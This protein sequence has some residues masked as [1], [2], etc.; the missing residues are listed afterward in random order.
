MTIRNLEEV[1]N[2]ASVALVCEGEAGDVQGAIALRNIL[3]GGYEGPFWLVHPECGTF[4]GHKCF[5]RLEDLPAAP[6][7]AVL[8]TPPRTVPERIAELGRKG[9]RIAVV[10]TPGIKDID[11]LSQ[12]VL[13]AAQPHML[14]VIGPDSLGVIAPGARL[15]ASVAH[16]MPQPGK[17]ALVSQS[18]AI[19][20][21]LIEWA[22]DH[23]I[24]F[25]HIVTMGDMADVDVS[26]YLDLLASDFN[27]RA[28]LIY[29]AHVQSARKFLSAARA[30]ARMKPVIAIK[31]GRTPQAARAAATHTGAMAAEDA[32]MDAALRRA[33]V[34]RVKGLSEM[35]A[36]AET[37]ARFRPL[38]R[39]RLGIV[40][41]GGGAG[42]LAVDR[43]MEGSGQLAELSPAT[44]EAFDAVLPPAWSGSNPVDILGD[45]DPARYVAALE[46]LA[47][48]RNVDVVMVI[49]C[50]SALGPSAAIAEAVAA[51][52]RRGMIG[53]KPVLACWLGGSEAREARRLMRRAEMAT[54]STPSS[55]AAAV[56]HL[57]DW[58]RAQAALL[59]VPDRAVEGSLRSTPIDAAETARAIF[60]RVAEGGR[61]MLTE[62]EAKAAVA[63][64]GVPVPGIREAATIEETA[65]LAEVML[66]AH[67]RVV[68]KLVSHEIL[69]KTDLGGVVLNIETGRQA[70]EAARAIRE[71]VE[72]AG[73][74]GQMAGFAIEP[75]VSR[76]GSHELILGVSLDRVFGPTILFGAGGIDVEVLRDT[77]VALPPLDASL[78]ADLVSRTRVGKVLTGF[79][80]RLPANAAALQGAIVALSLMV[81][82]FPCLRAVDINPILADADGVIALDAAIEIDPA[83]V[84]ER[85]PNPLLA[86]RP[87]PSEW[88]REY[89]LKGETYVIRP[90]RPAD[91]LLYPDFLAHVSPED[92]RMRFMAPRTQFPEE[93]ALKMTQLDYDRDMAFVAIGPDGT[94]AGV[95]RMASEPSGKVAEYA[96][97]VRSDLKGR[98]LGSTLMRHLIEYARASGVETLDGIILTENRGMLRL[99]ERLGFANHHDPEEAG[100]MISKLRL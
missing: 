18:A 57:T 85:G 56:G 75:M 59:R 81:E 98:G 72:T 91:A 31:A 8:A 63:A 67:G 51:K 50:P 24:G 54:F 29:L 92:I 71:R 38:D 27:T 93:M 33:G 74:A 52:T 17:L 87:Y 9:C 21:T 77:A 94:M 13:D 62:P 22:E 73:V 61:T 16:R 70:E 11:G 7:L 37:V 35:F 60:R 45:A 43:L 10:V 28:I 3:E 68:V 89:V 12:A 41:N 90:V 5:P 80:G 15:N 6:E 78:A 26:D 1:L 69:H 99:V 84:E 30:V 65:A 55:A 47:G 83:R 40:T 44:I 23:E 97:L 100:V 82:D 25:S 42:V 2:P 14:R 66:A 86:I 36:A 34:L 58:G 88:R 4:G 20:T 19:A 76:P 39:A 32:V 46:T 48:E 49:D 53:R 79:R 96:L 95:S 64:Y